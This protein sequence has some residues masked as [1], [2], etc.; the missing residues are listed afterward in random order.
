MLLKVQQVKDEIKE[1]IKYYLQTN[2]NENTTVQKYMGVSKSTAQ[3]EVHNNNCHPQKKKINLKQPNLQLKRI[4]K[5]KTN[6]T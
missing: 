5:R 6:K 4:R 1:E 2:D 3:R